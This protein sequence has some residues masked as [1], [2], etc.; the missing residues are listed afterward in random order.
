MTSQTLLIKKTKVD[1]Y[2]LILLPTIINLI[3][4]VFVVFSN[5]KYFNGNISLLL[6]VGL[7]L[8][9]V[10]YI[11][12]M[13][14]YVP[15]LVIAQWFREKTLLFQTLIV[16][17]AIVLWS[18]TPL[19][20]IWIMLSIVSL[21]FKQ[22]PWLVFSSTY[23]WAKT[24]VIPLSLFYFYWKFTMASVYDSLFDAMIVAGTVLILLTI[25]W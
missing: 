5:W 11:M 12:I 16:S 24:L 15:I 3:S 8:L 18:F 17:I 23:F 7:P 2:K 25:N 20:I 6:G 14:L 10:G 22:L 21:I 4:V 13:L 9:S 19:A 1:S